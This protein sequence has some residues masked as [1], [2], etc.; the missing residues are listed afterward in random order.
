METRTKVPKPRMALDASQEMWE[1]VPE[2]LQE[3]LARYLDYGELPGGFQ[4]A[5]L[6][7]D[8]MAAVVRAHGALT[9]EDLRIL[10]QFLF[11][12]APQ[13]SWG[14]SVKVAEWRNHPSRK[15]IMES[16]A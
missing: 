9:I 1:T 14:D 8:L 15:R 12:G 6:G 16:A 5:C 7:N 11:T 3:G 10:M 2:H 4:L 13:E